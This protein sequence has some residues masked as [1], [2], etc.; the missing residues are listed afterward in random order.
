MRQ[1]KNGRRVRTGIGMDLVFLHGLDSFVERL[2]DAG[3]T[4]RGLL[5]FVSKIYLTFWVD[6]SGSNC[7]NDSIFCFMVCF[8]E[9]LE[10]EF[11]YERN[12]RRI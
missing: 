9:N 1:V 7:W 10:R 5:L 3:I 2:S 4:I 11:G 6:A 12:C 8:T